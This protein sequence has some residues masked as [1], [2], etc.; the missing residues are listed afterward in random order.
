[1]RNATMNGI[2]SKKR[3]LIL[4]LS[5]FL[6]AGLFASGG[7][8]SKGQASPS[9]AK[10]DM[11][12]MAFQLDDLIT[13]DP[14]E[15]YELTG[16]EMMANIYDR[17]LF[18]PSDDIENPQPGLAES[19]SVSDDG[20]TYTFKIRKGATFH[21][22]NPVT[23]ED[24]AWSLQRVIKLNKGPA[25]IIGDLGFTAENVDSMI[26]AVDESTLVVTTGAVYA[27][28]Y[29]INCLCSG[30]GSIVD[31]KEAMAHEAGGDFGNGWLKT[32]D[33]GSGPFKLNTW[34]ANELVML[35][36]FD[37]YW[38]GAASIKRVALRHVPES[39]SQRLM[40]EKGDVDLARNLSPEDIA[41][42]G[43]REDTSV[44]S[45]PQGAIYYMGLNQKNTY[46][47]K[48]EVREALKWLVDYKGIEQN[49]LKGTKVIHQ[50]FLPA[51]VLGAIDD[52]PYTYDV[53]KAKALLKSAGLAD[54]FKITIDVTNA[55]PTNVIAEAIQANF[56]KAG[57]ELEILPGDNKQTLT[58]YRARQHDIYIGRWSPDYADPNSNTQG[59]AWN[60]DNSD[61]SS[62]KLLA[63]RN[64][65]D[66]PAMTKEAEA[67]LIESNVAKRKAMY[68]AMQREHLKTS[69][70][71]L[72]YQ[73]ILVVAQKDYVSGFEIGPSSDYI[74]YKDI[75]LK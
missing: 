54:G 31:K 62:T 25:F 21:S 40:Y 18:F 14:A 12:V 75:T 19:W 52:N 16:M 58:K 39:A 1:M 2:S 41:T 60:P 20:K 23:A 32:G 13:F 73:D 17:L 71:V 38:K 61:T 24:A 56:A 27:P 45:I 68:E 36:R 64:S 67:A 3:I 48:P 26:K 30:P 4:A 42:L 46:L 55:Y 59:F 44:R 65:W 37:G 28:S 69:P 34:K 51:G 57:I 11:V 22:G 47:A 74:Y 15:V 7:Q 29:V 43:K 49:I 35:D 8:E 33:A 66:I 6:T 5:V 50:S 9:A 63:W 70:F 53:E 10:K 72:M